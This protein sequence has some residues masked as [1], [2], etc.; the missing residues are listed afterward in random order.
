MSPV[1]L[2][3][4][5]PLLIE[6][7]APIGSLP[8]YVAGRSTVATG[9]TAAKLSSNELPFDPLPSVRAAMQ[10]AL[11][12]VNRYPL[13]R[14]DD[15]RSAVAA[16]IGVDRDEVAV[17]AGSSG[18]VWQLVS[19]YFAP[20]DR[21]VLH[22]PNFEAYPIA[23][24]LARA[25]PVYV[26]MRDWVSDVEALAASVDDKTKAVILVD[27][28]NPTGTG[29]G[30]D[31]ALRLVEAVAGR[32]L[33][34]LDQAYLDFDRDVRAE[35]RLWQHHPNVVVLRTFSK[36]HGL[37]ALR[38]GYA[39]AHPEVVSALASVSPPFAVSQ[40][41]IAAA[42]ASLLASDDLAERVAEV[43]LERDRV[44]SSLAQ[45]GVTVPRSNAN[46]IFLPSEVAPPGLVAAC[47]AAGV[48]VR[49]IGNDGI[50]VSIGTRGE[51]DRFVETVAALTQASTR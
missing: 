5:H 26:P 45:M 34:L 35:E 4:M 16:Y 46:F 33:V 15:L 44:C 48:I 2:P 22:T 28:H 23:I 51:N 41:A 6:P 30:P 10:R 20:G 8:S 14:A 27:P 40:V 13:A 31:A 42:Q 1:P 36:A 7:S 49:P 17:G 21:V 47:E 39:L 24:T 25:E 11:A 29:V 12:S 38:V 18:L 50:R 19:A 9:L 32:A 37:A 43:T 3:D